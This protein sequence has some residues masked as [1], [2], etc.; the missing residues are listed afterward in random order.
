M[1]DKDDKF[2]SDFEDDFDKNKNAES[3]EFV[4]HFDDDDMHFGEKTKKETDEF[5]EFEDHQ[6]HDEFDEFA[7]ESQTNEETEEQEPETTEEEG[8]KP[9]QSIFEYLKSNIIIL[10]V[11]GFFIITGVVKLYSMFAKAPATP[12]IQGGPTQ[13]LQFTQKNQ[14]TSSSCC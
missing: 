11:G 8:S 3:E 10:L 14:K 12:Q 2:S 13:N 7:E 9:G 6:H 5:D 4:D 1:N